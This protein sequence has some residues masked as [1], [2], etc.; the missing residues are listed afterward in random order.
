MGGLGEGGEGGGVGLSDGGAVDA[1]VGA[2]AAANRMLVSQ[3]G[4]VC[5]VNELQA[6]SRTS[7]SPPALL[8]SNSLSPADTPPLTPPPLTPT[9]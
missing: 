1:L 3:L 2:I 9:P 5:F 6:M 8:P 7:S 4:E